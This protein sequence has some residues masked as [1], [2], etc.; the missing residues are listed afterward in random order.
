MRNA[1]V[2]ALS[3]LIVL[4]FSQEAS[5]S[6]ALAQDECCIPIAAPGVVFGN[7]I[8]CGFNP[9]CFST[10]TS[11]TGG[12]KCGNPDDGFFPLEAP[13]ICNADLR[14]VIVQ[15]FRCA[16]PPPFH[17]FCLPRSMKVTV[18]ATSYC[19]ELPCPE[20][21]STTEPTGPT[22]FGGTFASELA[23][24]GGAGGEPLAVR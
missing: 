22:S 4:G 13:P 5:R 14:I 12:G 16:A 23:F 7:P 24:L 2:G 10:I 1:V 18:S 19:S 11:D 21:T 9:F 15:R 20:S 6:G 8:P 17:G 3:V